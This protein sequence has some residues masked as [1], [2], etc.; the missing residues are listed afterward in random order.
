MFIGFL[1]FRGYTE[2]FRLHPDDLIAIEMLYGKSKRHARTDDQEAAQSNQE[3]Q[4]DILNTL[5]ANNRD[6]NGDDLGQF[7]KNF[8]IK[9]LD[10]FLPNY[11]P[12][13]RYESDKPTQEP[14]FRLTSTTQMTSTSTAPV[15]SYQAPL[16]SVQNQYPYGLQPLSFAQTIPIETFFQPSH[17]FTLQVPQY[18]NAAK[19]NLCLEGTFDAISVLSDGYTYIFK[20]AYV[21]KMSSNFIIDSDYP[22]LTSSVF[23]RWHG[24]NWIT[25]PN[26]L[27][28]VLFVPDLGITY[29]FK[30]NLYWRSSKLYSLDAD[31][32]RLISENFNGLNEQNGFNGKLDASFV[33][34]GNRRVYFIEENRYWRYDFRTA[35]IEPGYPKRLSIWRGL[36]SRVTDAF[37]WLNGVTYFF[38]NERY[39]RFNDFAFKVEEAYPPYPRLNSENWFGCVNPQR[40]G[41]LVWSTPIPSEQDNATSSN[42]DENEIEEVQ[43]IINNEFNYTF[44]MATTSSI[45]LADDLQTAPLDTET[46]IEPASSP[47]DDLKERSKQNQT[48]TNLKAQS[49]AYVNKTQSND[50]ASSSGLSG[51]ANNR[52]VNSSAVSSNSKP[53]AFLSL[54]FVILS[55]RLL[56][57]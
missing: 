1:L 41:K 29:F 33:W 35:R 38:E 39:Y 48:M 11:T 52:L 31:Y 42:L 25:L 9:N 4:L 44:V 14:A 54:L 26:N 12:E 13:A 8:N 47:E 28:T 17:K 49:T 43:P 3:V 50:K 57:V 45:N 56:K 19:S 16:T 27:D 53:T 51:F 30:D 20:G 23:G 40:L 2:N 15:I 36:P 46:R 6:N 18:L 24:S 7:D 10:Q 22:K 21:Y 37:L 32:P 55:S 5:L 34:S